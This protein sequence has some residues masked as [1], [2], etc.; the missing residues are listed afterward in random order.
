MLFEMWNAIT[1][2]AQ[3]Q[4][5]MLDFYTPCRYMSRRRLP[6]PPVAHEALGLTDSYALVDRGAG[7]EGGGEVT[8]SP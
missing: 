8:D 6:V 4:P 5:K 1:I 2:K 7:P 3:G